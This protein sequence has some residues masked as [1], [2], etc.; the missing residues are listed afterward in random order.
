MAFSTGSN[1][2]SVAHP[3]MRIVMQC[4]GSKRADAGSFVAGDGRRVVFVAR[5]D[6]VEDTADV[7]HAHPDQ[8]SDRHGQTWRDRVVEANDR[9]NRNPFG[10]VPAAELYTPS[11]Y[12][13]LATFVGIEKLFILSAGWGLVAGS[14][15]LPTYDITF[16]GSAERHKRRR[17]DQRFQDLNAFE[18]E[19]EE[20]TV[21]VGGK[22]YLPLFLALTA[23]AKCRRHVFYNSATTPRV[24]GC[25]LHLFP[26]SR[27]TNWHY[28]C[29]EALARRH[30][31]GL[32][33]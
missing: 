30:L 25:I 31:T 11:A 2:W 33:I 14:Y 19:S 4:A 8:H 5:P 7:L 16:S 12:S 32:F 27:R 9:R 26:T 23:G 1:T 10:L 6:L 20:A 28:E 13:S 22:D 3:E 24:T 17:A 29:A 21:F 18:G 15:L